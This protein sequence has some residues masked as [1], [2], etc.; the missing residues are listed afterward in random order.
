MHRLAGAFMAFIFLSVAAGAQEADIIFTGADVVTMNPDQPR[1]EAVAVK[2]GRILAV[3]SAVSVAQAH[4]GAATETVVLAGKT[5]LPGLID[6]HSHFINAL[7]MSTQANV[8]AP[9]VGSATNPDEVVAELARYF[10]DMPRGA[11]QLLIGY[12]YDENLMPKGRPLTRYDLDK[13]F[14]DTPVLVMHVSL[15]GAVLNSAAFKKYQIGAETETPPG[16]VIVRVEGSNEPEGLLME[17]AFLPIFAQLPTPGPDKV[18]QQILDAQ[19]IYAKAGVTTGYEGATHLEQLNVLRDGADAGLLFLDVIALPFITDLEKILAEYP[20]NAWGKYNNRLKVGGC[21]I[22]ID[23]SPQGKTANFSTPYLTGGPEG[24]ENWFGEPTFPTDVFNEMV[25]TCYDLGVQLYIHT[26]GD[27]AVDM[28]LA[29]HELAAADDLQAD[30]RTIIVHSQF[31]RR[32]QLQKLV[33][34]NMTPSFYTEHTFFFS[35]AHIANRGLEQASYISPMRDAI[36][37]G[38]RPTN[39]TD[40]NVVPIDQMFVLWSAVTRKDRDDNVIGPDQRITP[41]EALEAITINAARQASEE[42]LKGSIEVGKLA[43]LVVLDANPLM[44][45]PD[46]IKNITVLR[47]VKEGKTIFAISPVVNPAAAYCVEGGNRYEPR[48]TDTGVEAICVSSDGSDLDAWAHFLARK[49]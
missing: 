5:L 45:E 10:K 47:T 32:D 31:I 15:H 8:S 7:A 19:M 22:T 26:N 4:K 44:V 23:G 11:D 42:T 41:Q 24:Q 17:T 21:K 25:Q 20:A 30:R 37:M 38:L 33:D 39:H 34:Y 16:G 28:A 48:Q 12:G 36:D 18:R 13:K 49:S 35:A 9:P 2:G 46:A 1:A 40:F 6:P 3:G 43:D 27:A 14:P 29:A